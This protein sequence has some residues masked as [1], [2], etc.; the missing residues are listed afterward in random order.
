[1]LY[2]CGPKKED[3]APKGALI[4]NVTSQS[5]SPT[6]RKFSPFFLG[7]VTVPDFGLCHNLENA[8]QYSKVYP[9]H[10]D[11]AG[12]L[13]DEWFAWSARGF[14]NKQAVRYPMGKGAI[15]HYSFWDNKFL[16]YVPAR[17]EIYLKNYAW[18][19]QM[20][21]E[22][23]ELKEF[24]A[25]AHTDVYLWDFDGNNHIPKGISFADIVEDESRPMGHSN[26]LHAV[27]TGEI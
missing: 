17:K 18:L 2:V 24:I 15:P 21:P 8:W 25:A 27:L 22:F 10:V 16:P 20:L 1:M 6:L 3:R 23:F 11:D 5:D 19:V 7:P 12:E 14:R 26:V 13:R 9:E 4:L